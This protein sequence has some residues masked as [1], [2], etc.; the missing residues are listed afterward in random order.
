MPRVLVAA[1]AVGSLFFVVGIAAPAH[2]A[3]SE[4][5]TLYPET[6]WVSISE[7]AVSIEGSAIPD[8]IA[9]RFRQEASIIG[10][11]VV[12]EIGPV[13]MTVCLVGAESTFDRGRYLV[14]SQQFHVVTDLDAALFAMDTKGAV[15]LVAPA[16]AFGMSQ[17]ALF[18]NNGG[19]PFPQP[20]ADVISQWYRARVLER[21]P[22][23]HRSQLGANWFESESQFDWTVGEQEIQ[24]RW[25]PEKNGSSIGDFVDFAVTTHGNEVLLE[26]DG[27]TWSEIETEWRTALRV[28]LTGRTTPTTGW[29]A[30]AALVVGI[31]AVT[32]L[33][34]GIGIYR[35]HK[36]RERPQTAAPIAGFF[37]DS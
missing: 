35:K 19:Q 5:A 15:G 8:G 9:D 20:I 23:Y 24:R 30:G 10:G 33:V 7:G 31:A 1:M 6:E 16:L 2:S 14:G 3:D 4:C 13:S 12:D 25:D 11:W 37:R 29:I 36:K 21:L 34:A 26:T 28:E 18:E 32:V 22:Y 17:Q 27:A